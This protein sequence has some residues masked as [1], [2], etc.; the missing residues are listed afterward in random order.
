[1]DS[2]LLL[3]DKDE[4]LHALQHPTWRLFGDSKWTG[5]IEVHGGRRVGHPIEWYGIGRIAAGVGRPSLCMRDTSTEFIRKNQESR[6]TTF[7]TGSGVDNVLAEITAAERNIADSREYFI[8]QRNKLLTVPVLT[9]RFYR[10]GA[11]GMVHRRLNK[12]TLR[13]ERNSE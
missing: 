13:R 8:L 10:A 1:L 12:A 2:R 11:W 3:S 7:R 9:R 4:A 5:G 6:L